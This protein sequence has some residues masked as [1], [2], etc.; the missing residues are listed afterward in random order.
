M[1]ALRLGLG[2]RISNS[3]EFVSKHRNRVEKDARPRDHSPRWRH[4]AGPIVKRVVKNTTGAGALL[5]YNLLGP[6][7]PRPLAEV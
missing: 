2:V 5:Q 3:R 4:F 7:K 1:K 6:H